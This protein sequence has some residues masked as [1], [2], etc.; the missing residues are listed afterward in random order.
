MFERIANFFVKLVQRFMPDPFLFAIILTF[1]AFLSAV[2]LT[3]TPII[4]LF[5]YWYIGFWDILT[6]AMQMVLILVTG[7][8]LAESPPV[9]R[10]LEAISRIPKTQSSAVVVTILSTAIGSLINWGFGLV[11]GAIV[12]REIAKKLPKVDFAFLVAGAYAGFMV[13]A[14]GLSSSIALVSATKGSKL[15][16]IEQV[17]GEVVPLGQMLLAPYNLVPVILTLIFVPLLFIL[18]QPRGEGVRNHHID[19]LLTEDN[20]ELPNEKQK[21]TF[22][23]VIENFWPINLV[24]SLMAFIALYAHFK[25]IGFKIDINSVIFIFLA[26]GLL[27]HWKPISYR[28]VFTRVSRSAGPLI[29]QYPIYG[30]L[31]GL[32]TLSGL[33]AIVAQVFVD[34]SSRSTLPFWSFIVS[35]IINV[36]V[37]SGGGQWAVQGPIMVSAAEK[38]GSPQGMTAMAVAFGDQT[39]NMIQ[40]FWALPI[41]AIAG[42]GIRDIM[43]YC[44]MAFVVGLVLFGGALLVFA[45]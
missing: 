45:P 12:A 18:M 34:F 1:V 2:L 28:Q 6:F 33:G 24:L 32:I 26:L 38:L 30:G 40:P 17:T 5:R 20:T 35:N 13:W 36:F 16:I 19:R 25:N 11:V 3:P 15:N 23:Q 29:L 9:K 10:F 21:K 39:A 31:M 43:G 41:L 22:A 8:A 4:D 37:P 27:F 42:L 7:H 44:I 14:S